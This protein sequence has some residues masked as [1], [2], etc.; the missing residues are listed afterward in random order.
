MVS[1]PDTQEGF[2]F[3]SQRLKVKRVEKNKIN[4]FEDL[5]VWQR[6]MDFATSIY[7]MIEENTFIKKDFGLKDQFKRAVLSISNNIAEGF[8]YSNNA[9]FYRYLRMA[10]GSCGETRNMIWFITK[11]QFISEDESS[12]LMNE[13]ITIGAQLSSLMKSV[14]LKINSSRKSPKRVSNL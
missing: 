6:A 8:E 10:K 11:L 3:L 7:K 14:R 13:V 9:D 4:S 1:L 5:L 12:P 2:L